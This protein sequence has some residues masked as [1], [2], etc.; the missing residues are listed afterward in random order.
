MLAVTCKWAAVCMNGCC[1]Q[2]ASMTNLQKLTIPGS[3]IASIWSRIH[4]PTITAYLNLDHPRN[5]KF[6]LSFIESYDYQGPI[7][8]YIPEYFNWVDPEKVE[9]GSYAANLAELGNNYG[10][11]ATTGSNANYG[12]GIENYVNGL[13]RVEEN[14]FY[15]P[16]PNLPSH[17]ER[18]YL[19][20][21]PQNVS[22]AAMEDYLHL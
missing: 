11:F 22:Q 2:M 16:L 9:D 1:R 20:A 4:T 5:Y 3:N 13:L 17:K 18:E 7:N 21:H 8:G 6:W 19:I 15:V 12:N 10:T 14:L